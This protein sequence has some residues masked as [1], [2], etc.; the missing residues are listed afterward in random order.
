M[1]TRNT[2][3]IVTCRIVGMVWDNGRFFE[4]NDFSK[5]FIWQIQSYKMCPDN[6]NIL[7]WLYTLLRKVAYFFCREAHLWSHNPQEELFFTV[8][9][10]TQIAYYILFYN[11]IFLPRKLHGCHASS[12]KVYSI[13]I[14]IILCNNGKC[15]KGKISSNKFKFKVV[16]FQY[17]QTDIVADWK[18]P[19]IWKGQPKGKE[20]VNNSFCAKRC[21]TISNQHNLV[22]ESFSP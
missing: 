7:C 9:K 13:E 4:S 11:L 18:T 6:S 16:L 19:I 2:I 14:N 1:S 5:R 22:Q 3:R 12:R 20:T 17:I 10:E 21:I 15:F 8:I